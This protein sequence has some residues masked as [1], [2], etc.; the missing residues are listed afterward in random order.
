MI[1]FVPDH[2]KTKNMCKHPVTKLPFI[3]GHVPDRYQTQQM[4]D[5]AVVENGGTWKFIPLTATKILKNV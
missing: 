3:T 4:C 2:L 5:K 1:R